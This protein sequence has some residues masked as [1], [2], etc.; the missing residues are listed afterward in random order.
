MV[1]FDTLH[2]KDRMMMYKVYINDFSIHSFKGGKQI[3]S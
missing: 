2:Q 3:K 1:G